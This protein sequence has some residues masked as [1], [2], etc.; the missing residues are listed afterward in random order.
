MSLKNAIALLL[1]ILAVV[2]AAWVWNRNQHGQTGRTSDSLM[3]VVFTRTPGF[4]VAPQPEVGTSRAYE[5]ARHEDANRVLELLAIAPGTAIADIGAGTGFYTRRLAAATGP[6]GT[7][8]ATELD[9]MLLTTLM[10]YA[11]SDP[12]TSSLRNIRPRWV[13]YEHVGLPP[14]SVDLAFLSHLDFYS[15]PHLLPGPQAHLKSIFAAVRPGGRVAVLQ[16]LYWNVGIDDAAVAN[17]TRQE[18]LDATAANFQ[19]AGFDAP[20]VY[21]IAMPPN[22][23]ALDLP[24]G[25][26]L[27]M[28]F[29]TVLFVFQKPR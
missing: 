12:A 2:T 28:A 1:S 11:S 20:D 9:P 10:A 23:V 6:G 17:L 21:P 5:R 24:P 7:V 13:G 3:E 18:I 22:P 29:D 8:F 15:V 14:E 4:A 26:S 16:W 27:A 25:V 19:A